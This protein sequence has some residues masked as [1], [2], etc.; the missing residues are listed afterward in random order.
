MASLRPRAQAGDRDELVVRARSAGLAGLSRLAWLTRLPCLA[1]AP[2][3]AALASLTTQA[4]L[5]SLTALA[6]LTT[7]TPPAA[8]ASGTAGRTVG[9]VVCPELCSSFAD[10]VT[11][12]SVRLASRG[13]A[14]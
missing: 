12:T 7:C 4:A 1:G 8:R 9:Y 10:G 13:Q 3:R 6:R 14:I 2:A 11:R 5:A